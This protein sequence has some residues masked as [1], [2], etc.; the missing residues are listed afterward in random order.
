MAY[1]TPCVCVRECVSERDRKKMA[2]TKCDSD[3]YI[4]DTVMRLKSVIASV[5]Y[6]I[7]E[8]TSQPHRHLP[9]NQSTTSVYRLLRVAVL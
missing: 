3:S 6:K 4:T 7:V 9:T 5:Y 8:F 1:I 2:D